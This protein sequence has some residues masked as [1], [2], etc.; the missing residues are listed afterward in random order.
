MI[1]DEELAMLEEEIAMLEEEIAM[2]EEEKLEI[3]SNAPAF[4]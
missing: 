3:R 4:C 2:L 1:A